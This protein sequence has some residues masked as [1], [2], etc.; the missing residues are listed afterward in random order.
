M[1]VAAGQCVHGMAQGTILVPLWFILLQEQQFGKS[2]MMVKSRSGPVAQEAVA[3]PTDHRATLVWLLSTCI[4]SVLSMIK[5]LWLPHST[6][7][8]TEAAGD[9]CIALR[10]LS[11]G[12][13]NRDL[14]T[15][16]L[17]PE[18]DLPAAMR[19]RHRQTEFHQ[20]IWGP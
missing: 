13:Q 17:P 18:L 11:L 8:E 4:F 16:S 5:A 6:K 14:N 1:E 20:P 12:G 3:G 7:E 19:S 10:T 2:P 9:P 15:N